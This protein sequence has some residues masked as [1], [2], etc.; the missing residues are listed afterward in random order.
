MEFMNSREML[1]G[2]RNRATT[3][4]EWVEAR[5]PNYK[6]MK[7]FYGTTLGLRLNFEEDRGDF[8]QFRVGS[9][10]TCLALLDV[11]KT[12]M[13]RAKG[14]IP[15]FEVLN[16]DVFIRSMKRKGVKAARHILEGEHVRLVDFYDPNGN[17]LQAF[18]W[19][20]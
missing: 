11:K 17:L 4:L 20:Q 8:I 18:Q 14:F 1:M 16:L 15:T 12:G 2:R 10:K 3:G 13:R 19:K 6:K 9:S 5:V 7:R